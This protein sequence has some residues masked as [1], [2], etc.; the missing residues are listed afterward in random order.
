LIVSDCQGL[1]SELDLVITN[2]VFDGS[3]EEFTRSIRSSYGTSG[4]AFM[5][6]TGAIPGDARH[7]FSVL[8]TTTVQ[9]VLIELTSRYGVA[10]SARVSPEPRVLGTAKKEGG[11][12]G[13]IVSTRTQVLMWQSFRAANRAPERAAPP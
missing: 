9:K 3:H 6:L 4:P 11:E 7:T 13:T 10:W 2:F 8:G 12:S 1:E 5:N